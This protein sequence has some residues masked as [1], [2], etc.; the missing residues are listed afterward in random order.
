[1]KYRVKLEMMALVI[2]Y[3]MSVSMDAKASAE[4]W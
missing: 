2:L 4:E 3:G 1:M